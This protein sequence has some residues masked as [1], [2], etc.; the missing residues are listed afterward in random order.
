LIVLAFLLSLV[1]KDALAYIDPG[2]GVLILQA[3][4]SAAFGAAFVAR[5]AIRRALGV[6]LR[7]AGG[8]QAALAREERGPDTGPPELR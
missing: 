8:R 5:K 1:P 3:V 6:C 2:Y 4:V 7:L